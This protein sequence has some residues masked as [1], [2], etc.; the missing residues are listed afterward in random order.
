[1]LKLN[2]PFDLFHIIFQFYYW[3]SLVGIGVEQMISSH[4][5]EM[6]RK[7]DLE[8]EYSVYSETNQFRILDF[9]LGHSLIGE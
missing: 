3:S 2:L 4:Y 9:W 5:S 6:K 1:M 8:I 7:M